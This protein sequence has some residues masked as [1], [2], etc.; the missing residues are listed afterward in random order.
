M[1]R[2]LNRKKLDIVMRIEICSWDMLVQYILTLGLYSGGLKYQP[3][4]KKAGSPT[5]VIFKDLGKTGNVELQM[6]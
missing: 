4:D 3:D 2:M 5:G 6:Q 1:N